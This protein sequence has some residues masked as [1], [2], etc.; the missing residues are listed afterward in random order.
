M[1]CGFPHRRGGV[2][3]G[4]PTMTISG[5]FSPQAWGCTA[6]PRNEF[7][8]EQV[9]PTGVGVYRT[10]CP[11]TKEAP[12]FPT[13]VGVY[14]QRHTP[15]RNSKAFSPQ[16]WGCTAVIIDD[17]LRYLVFPTGVGVYRLVTRVPSP[18]KRF[19]HRRGGVPMSFHNARLS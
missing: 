4:A 6:E 7:C 2:P 8:P 16:A 18:R 10:P 15:T 17:G 3:G 11:H 1:G 9:F 14:Q 13:G 19:P 12:V 5:T